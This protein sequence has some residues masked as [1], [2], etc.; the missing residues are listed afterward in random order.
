M[1]ES[2][3]SDSIDPHIPKHAAADSLLSIESGPN[4]A[5][6]RAK[7]NGCK[8]YSEIPTPRSSRSA[9]ECVSS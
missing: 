5:S 2:K 6:L 3:G 1:K 7:S 8:T 4:G 9:W